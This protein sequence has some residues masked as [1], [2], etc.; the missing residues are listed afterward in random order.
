MAYA[1][2][3]IESDG[4][5]FADPELGLKNLDIQRY[6]SDQLEDDFSNTSV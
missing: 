2:Q 1:T 5:F 6:S 3:D 4:V